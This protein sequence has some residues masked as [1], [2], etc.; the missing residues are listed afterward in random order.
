MADMKECIEARESF[1]AED[2]FAPEQLLTM[3]SH[4][5]NCPDCVAWRE[6][7][8]GIKAAAQA[9]VT[10]DVPEALTQKIVI[11][12]KRHS[13]TERTIVQTALVAFMTVIALVTLN[14]ADS[15]ENVY[16][17]FA[18]LI[19]FVVLFGLKVLIVRDGDRD[20]V[21]HAQA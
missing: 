5:R 11:A 16:G 21:A 20:E 9:M 14:I 18:W 7:M 13:D 4:L 10:Y 12:A 3:E 2:G 8:Y 1:D 15:F 17:V 19:C 6:E